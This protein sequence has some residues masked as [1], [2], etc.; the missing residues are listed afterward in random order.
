M[1]FIGS[2]QRLSSRII[3]LI[4]KA[5]A[6]G[7]T[8]LYVEPFV[9][10]ANIIDKVIAPC[11]IGADNDKYL[12]ELL[13][14]A[15]RGEEIP[16]TITREE[17]EAVRGNMSAYP[18]W[19][20]GLVGFCASYNAKFFGGYANGVHTKIG[21]VRNYTDEAIR[22]LKKQAP[23]LCSMAILC[24]DY[25][26]WSGL[27]GATIYCDPPYAG[28]TGYSGRPFDTD[29]FFD[30]CRAMGEHNIVI[31]SE[32]SAPGDFSE[33]AGF[34]LTATLDKAKKIQRVERLY[35]VGMGARLFEEKSA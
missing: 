23:S 5:I 17:Y 28:V 31:I 2:K 15:K 9:G 32:Y 19:Y 30:W 14:A 11:K 29:D 13:N 1:K 21:T 16:D 26:Q 8:G 20:V 18:D 25:K 10:G 35:T 6:E 12:I 3:P 34:T 27:K 33:I 24:C 4:H 22:N 7:Q